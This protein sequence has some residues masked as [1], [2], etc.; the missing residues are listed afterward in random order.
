MKTI[1]RSAA[2]CAALMLPAQAQ[3]ATVS[4]A[5]EAFA[6]GVMIS[7]NC[8]SDTIINWDKFYT[9]LEP[10]E[11]DDKL[12]EMVKAAL[13]PPCSQAQ[14]KTARKQ[15]ALPTGKIPSLSRRLM[16][17]GHEFTKH[18][19]VFGGFALDMPN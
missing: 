6:F 14:R 15:S 12:Y 18:V 4:A 17:R 7:D 1:I 19:S 8:V 11:A 3:S 2:L 10:I 13:S 5:T 9:A 16:I